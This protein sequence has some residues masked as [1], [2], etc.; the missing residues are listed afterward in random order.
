[1][2]RDG[3]APAGLMRTKVPLAFLLALMAFPAGHQD[4]LQ[5]DVSACADRVDLVG[6]LSVSARE[7][8][9]LTLGNGT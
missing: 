5:S 4:C 6:Q 2:A 3:T 7:V 1:M 8:P 9:L